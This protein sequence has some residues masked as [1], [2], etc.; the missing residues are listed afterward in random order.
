MVN[1]LG[2]SGTLFCF[3]LQNNYDLLA[4]LS[5]MCR[6]NTNLMMNG[7][8]TKGLYVVLNVKHLVSLH[9]GDVMPPFVCVSF[10][11]FPL[12]SNS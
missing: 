2:C 12:G 3:D 1:Q 10:L 4:Q 11:I 5:R 8:G 7:K 6:L 9:S